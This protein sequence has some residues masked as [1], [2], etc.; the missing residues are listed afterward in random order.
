MEI[1]NFKLWTWPCG[2]FK[3]HKCGQPQFDEVAL[4][5]F[6]DLRLASDFVFHLPDGISDEQGGVLALLE[7]SIPGGADRSLGQSLKQRGLEV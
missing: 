2:L 7:Q 3:K 1:P 5:A 4:R 6:D